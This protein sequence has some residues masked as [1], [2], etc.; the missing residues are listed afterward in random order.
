MTQRLYEK[1]DAEESEK[2]AMYERVEKSEGR[3]RSLEKQVIHV[4]KSPASTS[5]CVVMLKQYFEER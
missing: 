5:M 1:D 2:L 4:I 3:I